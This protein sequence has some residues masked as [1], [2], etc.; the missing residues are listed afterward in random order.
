MASL[1]VCMFHSFTGQKFQAQC[2]YQPQQQG[3]PGDRLGP[4]QGRTRLLGPA[5]GAES[6]QTLRQTDVKPGGGQ[7][8]VV[9]M[10]PHAVTHICI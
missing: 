5:P 3:L 10:L 8:H 4:V 6:P 1:W 7:S 2:S 9:L